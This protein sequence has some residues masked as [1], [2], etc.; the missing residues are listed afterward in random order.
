MEVLFHSA[1]HN[2]GANH[3]NEVRAPEA[4]V[5]LPWLLHARGAAPATASEGDGGL[6]R[7][8][9]K[10]IEHLKLQTPLTPLLPQ[11]LETDVW[12]NS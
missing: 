4:H 5:L 3:A 11:T 1:V 9:H 12:A 2:S 6:G 8:E 7:G 10:Q